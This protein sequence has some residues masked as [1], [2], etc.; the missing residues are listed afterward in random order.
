MD[1]RCRQLFIRRYNL[2]SET[3]LKKMFI[4]LMKKE[5]EDVRNRKLTTGTNDTGTGINS[6]QK[7]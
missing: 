6:L 5:T 1:I 4:I 3:Y 7:Q 2:T